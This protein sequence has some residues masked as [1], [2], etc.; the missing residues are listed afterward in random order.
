MGGLRVLPRASALRAA[1]QDFD[2]CRRL[3]TR[4]AW[5][6]STFLFSLEN[7][8]R[9]FM[10]HGEPA[11][12]LIDP[13]SEEARREGWPARALGVAPP[14]RAAAAERA[15][16]RKLEKWRLDVPP[17]RRCQ[18]LW[19]SLGAI[20]TLMPPRV[21]AATLRAN[22]N[23]WVT[24]RRFQKTGRCILGCPTADDSIQHYCHCHIFHDLCR[25]HLSLE[26]P[27]HAAALADFLLLSPSS[28]VLRV[29]VPPAGGPQ[30]AAMR[31][32]SVY[33]LVRTHNARRHGGHPA[34]PPS[35]L[36][37]GFVREGVR[38]HSQAMAL[39][40]STHKRRRARFVAVSSPLLVP[41]FRIVSSAF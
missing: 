12:L 36:F 11:R 5:A 18:R 31:A 13:A 40:S 24:S 30:A 25:R 38:G 35:D 8:M 7:A 2:G 15:L 20:K 1:M 37:G 39:L 6:S 22:L 33:A 4:R 34:G 32:L 29:G 3:G 28:R 14:P 19:R 41:F 23:G 9:D 16:R 27:E 21:L 26:R 17:G 10:A